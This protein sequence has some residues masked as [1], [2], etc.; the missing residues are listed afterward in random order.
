MARSSSTFPPGSRKAQIQALAA[1]RPARATATAV[2]LFN[3]GL[4]RRSSGHC[5]GTVNAAHLYV[6]RHTKLHLRTCM[7]EP[8]KH[9][10]I[11]PEDGFLAHFSEAFV[12]RY[13]EHW[14][15]IHAASDLLTD[16]FKRVLVSAGKATEE[17]EFAEYGSHDVRDALRTLVKKVEQ[18]GVEKPILMLLQEATGRRSPGAFASEVNSIFGPLAFVRWL[19]LVEAGQFVQAAEMS[20]LEQ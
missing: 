2:V 6:R 14:S 13:D 17:S 5:P 20:R 3:Q 18:A 9:L 1:T 7:T 4:T 15:Y 19:T 10:S 16:N 12:D 8:A 11:D